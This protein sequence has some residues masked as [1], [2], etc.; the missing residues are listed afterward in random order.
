[1]MMQ[2]PAFAVCLFICFFTFLF[3]KLEPP[4]VLSVWVSPS[5]IVSTAS[6]INLQVQFFSHQYLE[7]LIAANSLDLINTY[8]ST[9][10]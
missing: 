1:M 4:Y 5:D 2:I 3:T 9:L 8:H 7:Y 6:G 10:N